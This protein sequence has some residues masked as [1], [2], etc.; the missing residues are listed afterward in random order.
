MS[1][2]RDTVAGSESADSADEEIA[3]EQLKASKREGV[4]K[5]KAQY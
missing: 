3:L 5:G 1:F 2:Q 4:V